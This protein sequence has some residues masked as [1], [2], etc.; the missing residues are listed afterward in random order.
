M[1]D[2]QV[3]LSLEVCKIQGISACAEP[4][5]SGGWQGVARASSTWRRHLAAVAHGSQAYVALTVG[6]HKAQGLEQLPLF[7]FT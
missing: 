6:P 7:A 3:E 1:E 4:G 2:Y 5:G